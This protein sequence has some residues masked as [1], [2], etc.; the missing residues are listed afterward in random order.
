MDKVY[1]DLY[2]EMTQHLTKGELS[3]EELLR[4]KEIV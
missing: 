4:V 2:D 3:E 1:K